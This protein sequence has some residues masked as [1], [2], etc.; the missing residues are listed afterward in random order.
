MNFNEYNGEEF[1]VGAH[2]EN[3]YVSSERDRRENISSI[4]IIASIFALAVI[5]CIFFALFTEDTIPV[6]NPQ[7][8]TTPTTKKPN[9]PEDP[10]SEFPFATVTDKT[11]FVATAGGIDLDNIYLYSEHAILVRLSDMSTIAHQ[12]ADEVM[13]PASMTKVMTV[14]VA[15]DYIKDLDDGYVVVKEIVE[16][17]PEGASNAGLINYVGRTVTVRDLLYGITYISAA[18]SVLCLIDYLNLTVGQFVRL[19]NE[20]AEEI[21]LE[22]T[23]FGGAIGM[24]DEENSSTCRDI[25]ALMAYAMENPLC[26]EL[27]GGTQYRMDYSAETYYNGTLHTGLGDFYATP[28]TILDGYTLLAAKSG[29]EVKAGYCLVSYIENNAT[30][31]RFVLVT[32]NAEAY[33]EPYRKT[34]ILDMIEL[35]EELKP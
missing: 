5:A 19:M 4:A 6:F 21:G 26:K 30:G 3:R 8:T 12:N 14:V 23:V 16:S 15:L 9:T 27:F 10:E 32:A 1:D 25:A 29:F 17:M 28:E 18:D 11:Q 7:S 35:F 31:E 34:R 24:D 2:V 13:Y 33:K 20:K 22:N